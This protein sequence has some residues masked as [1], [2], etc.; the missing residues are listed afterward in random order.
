[1]FKQG[2]IILNFRRSTVYFYDRS[3]IHHLREYFY[4]RIATF[5]E[6]IKFRKLSVQ[7]CK[8]SDIGIPRNWKNQKTIK[9]CFEFSHIDI[10]RLNRVGVTHGLND[11]TAIILLMLKYFNKNDLAKIRE[12]EKTIAKQKELIEKIKKL[13]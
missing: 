3:N 5:S 11:Y 12:L 4:C 2:D 1:M 7:Q 8:L 13:F 6:Q 9:L 10:L